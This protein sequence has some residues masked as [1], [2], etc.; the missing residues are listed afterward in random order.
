MKIVWNDTP[1]RAGDT[2]G[3][4]RI[5]NMEGKS[6]WHTTISLERPS[7]QHG[8]RNYIRVINCEE[9]ESYSN[10][11]IGKLEWKNWM[12]PLMQANLSWFLLRWLRSTG[13]DLPQLFHSFA[14]YHTPLVLESDKKLGR[15]HSQHL[16]SKLREQ[17]ML[18]SVKQVWD[19]GST[20]DA[21]PPTT[22]DCTCL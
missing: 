13:E 7:R 8:R 4:F 15:L 3:G 18:K 12:T 22:L 19:L 2:R 9:M 17:T 11:L 10:D 14:Q 6:R 20:T 21:S 5:G 16:A 1:R